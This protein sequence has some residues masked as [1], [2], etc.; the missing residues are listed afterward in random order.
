MNSVIDTELAP[1][2]ERRTTFAELRAG[3][4]ILAGSFIGIMFGVTSV[5]FYST[6][7]FIKPLAAEFGWSRASLSTGTLI[8]V[9]MLAA[10]SPLCGR[11]VDRVGARRLAIASLLGFAASLLALS[12]MTGSFAQYG[13]IMAVLSAIAV[14]TTPLTFT[15]IVNQ[16]F[17]RARGLAL[18]LTLA[19]PGVAAMLTPPLIGR[20]V[21]TQGW[22]AGYAWLAF[23]V[24]SITPV[25]AWLLR[26]EQTTPLSSHGKP[27]ASGVEL[28]TAVG[29]AHF[30][31]LVLILISAALASSGIVVHLVPML[32]DAGMSLAQAGAFAALMGLAVI[33]GRVVTGAVVDRVFAPRVALVILSIAAMGCFLMAGA[34]PSH[35][36]LAAVL[37]GFA[38]GAEGDLVSYLVARYFGL[39]AY[40]AIYG[41]QYTAFL[42][43]VAGG[44]VI[45]GVLYDVH[46]NYIAALIAAGGAFAVAA[47]A[48]T[49]LPRFAVVN[50]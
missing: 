31:W 6:G 14:G 26:S 46:G 30:W 16:W 12:R 18:G 42:L 50:G 11:V 32:S 19:G 36:P 9:L 17:T 44:P 3:W 1:L 47:V 49:R 24:L 13:G 35:A 10:V 34:G 15:R 5:F 41:C 33:L 27:P 45:A 7:V 25:V 4:K 38:L 28:R 2:H 22:R 21:A 37:I 40:G 48:A 23:A 20:I 39:R 29:T 43:G 8:S